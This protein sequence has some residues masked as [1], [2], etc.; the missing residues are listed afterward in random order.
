MDPNAMNPSD[1]IKQHD[2]DIGGLKSRVSV[3]ENELA[4]LRLAHQ[5]MGIEMN[6]ALAHGLDTLKAAMDLLSAEPATTGVPS[7]VE[8]AK[9]R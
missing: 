3:V 9:A 6:A 4:Q 1:R 8:L 7:P 2:A 5:Q